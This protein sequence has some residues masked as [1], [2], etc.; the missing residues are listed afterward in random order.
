MPV[1]MT[2][3]RATKSADGSVL[4]EFADGTGK[5]FGTVEE[6]REFIADLDDGDK[7][8]ELAKLIMLARWLRSDPDLSD[9]ASVIGKVVSINVGAP[10]V[11]QI[12]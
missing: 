5:Q 8:R 2:C 7:G 1:V 4:I 9:N 11:I 3:T 6:L 12:G 10:N